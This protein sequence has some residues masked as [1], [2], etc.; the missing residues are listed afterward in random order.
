MAG[1]FSVVPCTVAASVAWADAS[2]ASL[3]TCSLVPDSAT[4]EEPVLGIDKGY[5]S[6]TVADALVVM[7]AE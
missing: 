3:S 4:V 1:P 6:I 5:E 2:N 7:D